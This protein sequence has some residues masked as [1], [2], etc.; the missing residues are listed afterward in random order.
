MRYTFLVIYP[1]LFYPNNLTLNT[2]K[3]IVINMIL[4][5]T[6]LI[7]IPTYYILL[8]YSVTWIFLRSSTSK[9]VNILTYLP[10]LYYLL[11][12]I[13]LFHVLEGIGYNNWF[14]T[15]TSAWQNLIMSPRLLPDWNDHIKLILSQY[16]TRKWHTISKELIFIYV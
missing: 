7:H 4:F 16:H 14:P 11:Y 12:L 15:Y 6:L 1:F 9:Y 5:F 13:L 2:L 10:L 3:H 8:S